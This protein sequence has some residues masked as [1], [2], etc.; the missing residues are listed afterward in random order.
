M[1]IPL[2]QLF[3]I[4]AVNFLAS[5]L[6]AS[7]GFGYAIFAMSLMPLIL[8]MRFCASI[9]AVTE[10]VMGI[11][12]V[13]MLRKDLNPKMILVPSLSCVLTIPLGMYIL[14]HSPEKTL[15]VILAAFI[16][17]LDLYFIFTQ[18]RKIKIKKCTRNGILFG[19]ISGL[20]TGMFTITGPF[21]MVYYFSLCENSLS[22]KANIEFSFLI[23][24][25]FSTILHIAYG[26]LSVAMLPYVGP[27]AAIAIVAGFLGLMLYRR[28]KKEMICRIMYAALP[29]M[30][31][32]LIR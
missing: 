19:L 11:Q 7:V 29:V 3:A 10:V 2:P 17:L 30:A 20:S 25:I 32:F 18:E 21:L 22:F 12:M 5:F 31:F 24:A 27:A 26:N 13:V 16:V 28:L 14:M 23:S 6:Q 9:T 1:N 8:P 15:R 4:I